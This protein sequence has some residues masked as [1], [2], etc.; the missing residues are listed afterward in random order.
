MGEEELCITSLQNKVM[1]FIRYKIGDKGKVIY[2]HDC[3][4]GSKEPIVSLKMV[5]E[6]D[7]IYNEDGTVNHSDLFCNIVE[8]INL[9]LQQAILQYQIIQT[10]YKEFDVYIV[11]NDG[12]DAL[13]IQ[14]LFVEF[15][16][17]YQQRS[18]FTFYF[19][20]YLYPGEKTGKLAWY[21]SKIKG[22]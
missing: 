15:Y 4:C 8:K 14:T 7:W 11:M 17:K 22:E 12:E 6:N 5:R 20:D 18:T 3:P 16:E 1:P 13:R 2:E 19:V 9:M 10:N 21:I